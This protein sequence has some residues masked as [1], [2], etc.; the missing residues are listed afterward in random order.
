[1][2]YIEKDKR[3]D[4]RPHS[5]DVGHLTYVFYK[6]ALDALPTE[7]RF[8]DMHAVLGAMEAAKHEFYRRIMAPYEDEAIVRNGDVNKGE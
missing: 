2:P 3:A 7:P 8:Q 6:T 4:A 5:N 1:M